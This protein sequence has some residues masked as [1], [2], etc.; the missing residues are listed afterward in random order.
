MGREG[1]RRG[2]HY[3]LIL[4]KISSDE[5]HIFSLN[6]LLYPFSTHAKAHCS[7]GLY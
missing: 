1:G 6:M 3:F 5:A 2:N 7:L 4:S